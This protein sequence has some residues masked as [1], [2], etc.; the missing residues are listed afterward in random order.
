MY[1]KK[2]SLFSACHGKMESSWWGT[3]IES[4]EKLFL[5]WIFVLG[6]LEREW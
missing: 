4:K 6:S 3:K 2:L 1:A 5:N